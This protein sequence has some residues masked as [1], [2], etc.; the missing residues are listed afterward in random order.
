[1]IVTC[2][3]CGAL[4][5]MT[6]KLDRD[7][8]ATTDDSTF[9]HERVYE[10]DGCHRLSILTVTLD[11]PKH[12]QA[13][14]GTNRAGSY[15]SDPLGWEIQAAGNA[16][17]TP[18]KGFRREFEDVPPHIAQA[19]SEATLCHSTGAYRAGGSLARAVVEA[20]AKDK[21]ANGKNLEARIDALASAG[22]IREH[23]KEQAHEIRHFGNGM[24]HGDFADPVSE[25]E[26]AEVLELMS[27]VLNEVYQSPAR[28]AKVKAAREARKPTPE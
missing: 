1:M 27:E 26:S 13:T 25:E 19:A 15:S 6:S 20:T 23:T 4:A 16:H 28:L 12:M 11:Q 18:V 24:A 9:H 3:H 7:H 8:V 21:K 2:G 22:H 5:N 14:Q 10:C 17:W